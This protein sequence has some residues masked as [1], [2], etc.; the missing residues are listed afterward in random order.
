MI[1]IYSRDADHFVNEVID[2]LEEDYIRIGDL[3]KM[4]IEDLNIAPNGVIFNIK[5][6]FFNAIDLN[7]VKTIWFNGGSANTLGS[8]YENDSYSLLVNSFLHKKEVK[9]IG[10]LI[11]SFEVNKLD[12][13]LYAREYGFKTPK[14]F[15]TT[16]KNKLVRFYNKFKN[17]IICKRMTDVLFYKNDEFAYDFTPTFLIDSNTL[18][19]IPDFFAVSLFQ[20]R[21]LADFEVRVVYICGKFYAMAIHTFEDNVDYRHELSMGKNVRAVPFEL[22]TD[23][24]NKITK[25][26]KRLKLNYGA[27]DLMYSG[28][29]FYF[30]EINPVGQVGFVNTIC[31]FYIEKELSNI[32]KNEA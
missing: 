21:I 27:I 24:K 32:L 29:E 17:G 23:V 19:K 22:P 13:Q 9:K 20:E 3:D 12:V 28:D 2:Y 25:I 7:R 15:I 31:N 8:K 10:R 11:N 16:D 18:K 30:L 5:G 1:L 4:Y 26:V 6:E 14:T